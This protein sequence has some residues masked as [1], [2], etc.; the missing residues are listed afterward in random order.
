METARDLDQNLELKKV[1]KLLAKNIDD[2]KYLVLCNMRLEKNNTPSDQPLHLDINRTSAYQDET[3]ES[4]EDWVNRE[5]TPKPVQKEKSFFKEDISGETLEQWVARQK[6]RSNKTNSSKTIIDHI[7]LWL[8]NEAKKDLF[9]EMDKI[10]GGPEGLS[11]GY[12]REL[13]LNLIT[14]ANK[15]E[16]IK[17]RTQSNG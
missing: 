12:I 13:G 14:L 2:F 1:R 5:F 16:E 3:T 9:K 15:L 10:Y 4:L 6:I 8:M 7:E 11:S 17:S